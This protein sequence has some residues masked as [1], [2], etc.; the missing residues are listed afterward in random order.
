MKIPDRPLILIT[1]GGGA[2]AQVIVATFHAAHW[3]TAAPPR[4][5]LDVRDG[6]AVRDYVNQLPR[7]DLLVINAAL[8][9]DAPFLKLEESAWDEVLDTNLRGAWLCA[10]AVL[11][12]MRAQGGGHIITLGSHTARHG[13]AGQAAYGASKAALM[14]LTQS[15]AA[16]AGPDNIR[17]N[18]VL[19]GWIPT[20]FNAGVP[21]N[22]HGAVRRQNHLG[23]FNT[24][25]HT[26]GF[27]LAL[28][29]MAHTSGQ[30]FQLDSRPGSWL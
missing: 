1:G 27:L 2:L 17:V 18:A 8:R 28:Q 24:L 11:P 10:R 19:P 20:P 6:A 16:E 25:E 5:E 3:Q 21:E 23:R 13:V 7:V 4:R 15:F 29:G 9:R 22:V 30:V 12:H 26:A 14:A